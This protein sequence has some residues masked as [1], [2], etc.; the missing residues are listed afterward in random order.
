MYYKR[1]ADHFLARWRSNPN[2]LP[3]IVTGAR[4]VGKTETIRR[5]A[6][7]NYKHVVTINFVEEPI[8]KTII[9]DGFKP[10]SIVKNISRIEPG[11]RFVA[12]ETLIFL[13]EVQ[14]L[15]EVTTALKFFK[16]DGRFDVICSGSLLGIQHARVQ[17]HSVGFKQDYQMHSFDFEEFLWASGYP[18]DLAQD[19]LSHL[20]EMRPFS[21]TEMEMFNSLFLD[22]IILGGMPAVVRKYLETKTFEWTFEIQRQILLDYREDI[23]KYAESLDKTKILAVFNAITPQLAKGHKKFQ[24]TKVAPNARSRE[25]FG[26][27]EWLLDAGIILQCQGLNFPALPLKGNVDPSKYKLYFADTGLLVAS[28]EDEAQDD[29]RR[30]KNLGVYKGAIY[31]NLVAEALAKSGYDLFYYKK[32]DSS[33]EL[34]FIIRTA[35]HIVPLEVKAG[36]STS[37]SLNTLIASPLYPEINHGIKLHR[38]NLGETDKITTFPYFCT[39]LIKDFIRNTKNPHFT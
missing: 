15:P 2:R 31:E 10:D 4:Q 33:L 3:L 13:D 21:T 23:S 1:K 14:E 29:L 27:V 9:D 35:N 28:L 5:F 34:D 38:G 39:F 16:L 11:F 37:K 20:E 30:N 17:S 26:C 24:L 12:E 32:G 36:T 19:M 22:Y 6:E 7:K 18:D 8:Y 25:Y